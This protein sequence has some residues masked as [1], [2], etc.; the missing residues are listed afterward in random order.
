[1][2]EQISFLVCLQSNNRLNE[3]SK[4]GAGSQSLPATSSLVLGLAFGDQSL[5]LALLDLQNHNTVGLLQVD[6]ETAECLNPVGKYGQTLQV[7]DIDLAECAKYVV[8]LMERGVVI[9]VVDWS[10]GGCSFRILARSQKVLGDCICQHQTPWEIEE[11]PAFW[12]AKDSYLH[13]FKLPSEVH[14]ATKISL[15]PIQSF[16]F[17]EKQVQG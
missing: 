11:E 15:S 1:M 16:A 14:K 8:M 5:E 2:T 12:L 7:V 3:L 9:A 6:K 13:L 17:E 10:D 4:V